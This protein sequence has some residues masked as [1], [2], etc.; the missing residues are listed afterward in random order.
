[1]HQRIEYSQIWENF[2]GKILLDAFI[3]ATLFLLAIFNL[4]RLNHFIPS[5][6]RGE[7]QVIADRI[8]DRNSQELQLQN[9]KGDLFYEN[10]YLPYYEDDEIEPQYETSFFDKVYTFVDFMVQLNILLVC[11]LNILTKEGFTDILAADSSYYGTLKVYG[12]NK[13]VS[14]IAV[15]LMTHLNQSQYIGISKI[16]SIQ[17]ISTRVLSIFLM[18]FIIARTDYSNTLKYNF[19][20]LLMAIFYLVYFIFND[21]NNSK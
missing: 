4:V 14:L 20:Q 17:Y 2:G 15:F 10:K 6:F 9:Q 16:D 13:N 12:L 8:L 11:F 18:F 3:V 5:S 19:E 1:M 21:Y 7:Y